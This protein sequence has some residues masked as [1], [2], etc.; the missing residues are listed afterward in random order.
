MALEVIA[1]SFWM[2]MQTA[3]VVVL[4]L[5]LVACGTCRPDLVIRKCG[6]ITSNNNADCRSQRQS[7]VSM[8][9]Q[10]IK[11]GDAGKMVLL[12]SPPDDG[13]RGVG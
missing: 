4:I 6:R 3:E 7:L 5:Y 9:I 11:G 8:K 2:R 1:K 10:E 13:R 12:S